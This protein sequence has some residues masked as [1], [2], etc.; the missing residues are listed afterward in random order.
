MTAAD[1]RA[2]WEERYR[3]KAE[4]P[5]DLPSRF[6]Q[7]HLPQLPRGLALDVACGDGRNALFLA[8][9]GFTVEAIDIAMAGLRRAQAAIRRDRL[10]VR[11]IQADLVSFPLRRERYAVIINIRYLER[12]LWP[13]LKR[14]VREGGVI[15][16]E[17]FLIDQLQFGHP[18]NPA[19]LLERG[20]LADA[21]RDFEVGVY[22]EG[23]FESETNGAFFARMVARRPRG[24]T[25][26]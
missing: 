2:R 18:S 22:E 12:A 13:A 4:R 19:Y 15:V 6:L 21:F 25:A 24:W 1:D 5:L 16:V 14:A 23:L 9:H 8:R 7:Q 3:A 10:P 17:T 11:L 20:E 26:D